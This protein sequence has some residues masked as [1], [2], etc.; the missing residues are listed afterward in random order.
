MKERIELD[1]TGCNIEEHKLSFIEHG[2]SRF[3]EREERWESTLIKNLWDEVV[4]PL[5][6]YPLYT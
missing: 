5:K 2:Q 1:A 4:A 6:A 3:L